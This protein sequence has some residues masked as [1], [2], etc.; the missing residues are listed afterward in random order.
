PSPREGRGAGQRP[1]R[2]P[3]VLHKIMT[4]AT[5]VP[6]ITW[7]NMLARAMGY[8]LV[9]RAHVPRAQVVTLARD[10]LS[11]GPGGGLGVSWVRWRA[12][13]APAPGWWPGRRGW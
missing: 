10:D 13:G 2:K 1:A 12:Q 5:A 7:A 9:P 11:S 6:W 8:S 4:A 3:T